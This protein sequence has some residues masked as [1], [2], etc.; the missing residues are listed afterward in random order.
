MYVFLFGVLN[1]CG[2]TCVMGE[3]CRGLLKCTSSGISNFSLWESNHEF[4][5]IFFEYVF[6]VVLIF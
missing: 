2:D 5:W 3:K 1:K 6:G 4:F